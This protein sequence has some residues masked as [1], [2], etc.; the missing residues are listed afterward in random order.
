MILE[1]REFLGDRL[2]AYGTCETN[3]EAALRDSW[4]WHVL[5]HL[6]SHQ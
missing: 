4:V 6:A 2:C 1:T 5:H 3:V